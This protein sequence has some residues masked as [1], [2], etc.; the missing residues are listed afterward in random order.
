[1]VV[2]GATGWMGRRLVARAEERGLLGAAVSRQGDLV[3][4]W[5]SHP[6]VDLAKLVRRPGA[7]VVNA[8]GA[9]GGEQTTLH[10][11][12]VE[13]VERLARTCYAAGAGLVTL[14]SAA[15]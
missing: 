13:L 9:T 6:L 1:M 5:P 10:R 2:V 4:T 12:N 15:E 14:G 8:A 3:G 7:V 11:A